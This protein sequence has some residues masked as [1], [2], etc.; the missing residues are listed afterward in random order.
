MLNSW[1]IFSNFLH[2]IFRELDAFIIEAIA[3]RT[4]T[5]HS[6]YCESL[7]VFVENKTQMEVSFPYR[8]DFLLGEEIS[9]QILKVREDYKIKDII[10]RWVYVPHCTSSIMK[11]TKFDVNY[12][13]G[14]IFICGILLLVSIFLI[15]AENFH[16]QVKM[17]RR[18]CD[19]HCRQRSSTYNTNFSN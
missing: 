8:K 14:I 12:F 1:P 10:E 15:L 16:T 7:E 4:I 19:V 3:S 18:T 2:L 5:S 9:R 13:G 11:F 6:K 17:H